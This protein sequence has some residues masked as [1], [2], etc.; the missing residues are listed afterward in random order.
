MRSIPYTF[1]NGRYV[2]PSRGLLF[3]GALLLPLAQLVYLLRT[4]KPLRAIWLLILFW[5][6]LSLSLFAG[7]IACL[8]VVLIVNQF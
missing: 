2:V 1:Y 3:V 6:T 8:I 4:R 7:A 5:I